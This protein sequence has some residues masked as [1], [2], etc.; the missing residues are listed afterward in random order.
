MSISYLQM[1]SGLDHSDSDATAV[2]TGRSRLSDKPNQPVS[3]EHILVYR[4]F[5]V[6]KPCTRNG[7]IWTEGHN[8]VWL[9][10][11]ASDRRKSLKYNL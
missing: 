4:S 6:T 2:N 5:I 9:F 7:G 10:I 3:T 1:S 11:Q 8:S